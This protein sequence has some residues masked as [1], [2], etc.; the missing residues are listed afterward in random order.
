MSEELKPCPFCGGTNTTTYES[1]FWTGQRSN[2][3]YASIRHW[4]DNK[5]HG[6]FI[7]L[8]A[9]SHDEARALWNTPQESGDDTTT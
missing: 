7:E 6:G 3:I 9:G 4:C 5:P 1:T 2:L 8:K